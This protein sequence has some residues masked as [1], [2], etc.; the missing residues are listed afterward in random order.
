MTDRLNAIS[1]WSDTFER[2][3]RI[4]TACLHA[5]RCRVSC[6]W[7]LALNMIEILL[8]SAGL[9]LW[10]RFPTTARAQCGDN[11]P[12]SSCITCHEKEAPVYGEGEWHTIH[13]R[14]DCCTNCHSGNCST[15]EKDLAHEGLVAQPLEDIYTNCYPCHPDDYEGRADRFAALLDV[16]PSSLPTQTAVPVAP[17]VV[18]PI[19][20]QPPSIPT[21]PAPQA[22]L[23]VL[24]GLAFTGIL[25][26]SSG[27]IYYRLHTQG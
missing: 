22:W 19:V 24:G 4:S 1:H 9:A 20:I 12:N 27:L 10:A 11:P 18:H 14:K 17:V 15:I 5:R 16:T 3:D 23:P 13:A 21:T 2:K 7:P 8:L 25:L 6:K 26:L